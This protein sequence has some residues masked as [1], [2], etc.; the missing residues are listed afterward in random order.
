MEID[1]VWAVYFSA[2]DTTKKIVTVLAGEA[3]RT[4]RAEYC[5]YDFTLPASRKDLL[6]FGPRDLVIF[7]TP[8]YAGRV[9]NVLLDFLK[10]YNK[11]NHACAVPVTVY[12]NRN[13]DDA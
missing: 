10:E 7:G 9:P 5:E 2:T 8:V 13:Y 6:V 11:G 12:G 1:R 4:L 3:A